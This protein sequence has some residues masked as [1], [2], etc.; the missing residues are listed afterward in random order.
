MKKVLNFLMAI[1]FVGVVVSCEK[2]I[3]DDVSVKNVPQ[4]VE[5]KLWEHQLD[6]AMEHNTVIDFPLK[7]LGYK[8]L[9]V[10]SNETDIVEYLD[11]VFSSNSYLA[12]DSDRVNE[13]FEVFQRHEVIA[14]CAVQELD[15]TERFEKHRNQVAGYISIGKTHVVEIYWDYNGE[16]F[17]TWA[18]VEDGD[19]GVIYDNVASVARCPRPNT[20]V[21]WKKYCKKEYELI[22]CNTRGFNDSEEPIGVSYFHIG[23]HHFEKNIFGKYLWEYD[24]QCESKFSLLSGLYLGTNVMSATAT[25][26]EMWGC[27]AEIIT[28][29]GEPMASYSHVFKWGYIYGLCPV[30]ISVYGSGFTFNGN[31]EQRTEQVVHT[32]DTCN[33]AGI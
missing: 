29:S 8:Y 1:V 2:E 18:L 17:I 10:I 33:N 25:H 5:K 13:H 22:S 30:S 14:G 23:D 7:M 19:K 20:E 12:I 26:Q 31:G 28:I 6:Y 11:F 9:G 15:A 16:D 27:A 32:V 24:I 3:K 4:K 21:T